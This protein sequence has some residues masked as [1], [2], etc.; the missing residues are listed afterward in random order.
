M[1][2]DVS[3]KVRNPV[4]G[5]AGIGALLVTLGA[6]LSHD[7]LRDIGAALL[8]GSLAVA[9]IGWFSHDPQ[10]EPFIEPGFE[11]PDPEVA[12]HRARQTPS[13]PS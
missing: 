9:W 11:E 1:S 3:P 8:G 13:T 5:L 2:S 4:L 7:R 10:R 6:A 12:E